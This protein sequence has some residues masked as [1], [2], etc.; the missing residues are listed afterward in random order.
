MPVEEGEGDVVKEYV[1]KVS[2]GGGRVS[3][4][5]K[6]YRIAHS[7]SN[8]A[9]HYINQGKNIAPNDKNFKILDFLLVFLKISWEDTIHTAIFVR[10]GGSKFT[11]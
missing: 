4:P 3:R 7:E 8:I 1:E 9:Q 5:I 6:K 11:A 2:E 10:G